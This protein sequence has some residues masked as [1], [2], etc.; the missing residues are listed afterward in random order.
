MRLSTRIALAVGILVPLLVIAA[1]SLVVRW[2]T[3]DV[4]HRQDVTLRQRADRLAPD[5]RAL[6][7]A[8]E[9]DRENAVRVRETKLFDGALDVGVRVE[10]PG[11]PVAAGPQP[12]PEVALPENR[13]SGPV[14]VRSGGKA[15]RVITR[16]LGA[17]RSGASATL[18]VFQPTA[19]T[20]ARTALLRRRVF[21]VALFAVPI[22]A[23]AG[24]VVAGT[25][26]R[27]LRALRRRAAA[28]EPDD[29]ERPDVHVPSGVAEVDELGRTLADVLGRYDV[30]TARTRDALD[31]ASAFAA[32]VDH[33]LR[34]PLTGMRTDLDVLVGYPD[35]AAHER[36]EVLAD[37]TA[38]HERILSLLASLRA[39]AQ[40]DLADAQSFERVDLVELAHE[41][42]HDARIRQPG[43]EVEV[44]G[45]GEVRVD[46]LRP[47]LRLVVDNLIGNALVH[48]RGPHG[49]T[50]IRVAVEA[51]PDG[52]RI[53][54]D[55]A[56]PGIPVDRRA[57]V[58]E[59]FRRGPDSPGAGLGLTLVAQQV[60]LHRGRVTVADSP[61]G[62]GTRVEVVLPLRHPAADATGDDGIRHDWLTREPEAVD[63]AK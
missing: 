21:V 60:E 45:S 39:L 40:G 32:T 44:V 26:T 16:P 29:R 19:E 18:R 11:G 56:G 54:V 1:G 6:L 14:T 59:R 27:S 62:V 61:A 48:G 41:A 37:L 3:A 57:A 24:L 63:T 2:V 31:T 25:T 7:R 23:L 8:V 35:L 33:E 52:V 46:G 43:A 38:G 20:E 28:I 10:L 36:I 15:W 50:P 58:F 53:R 9:N 42:A 4:T 12:P 13:R 30:Q 5:A 55:D 47:G 17:T 22:S 34:G 49:P 51:V